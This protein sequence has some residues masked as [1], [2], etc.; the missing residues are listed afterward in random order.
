L[1]VRPLEA[2]FVTF[3]SKTIFKWLLLLFERHKS[4]S[5]ESFQTVKMTLLA[6]CRSFLTPQNWVL[7]CF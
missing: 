5:V 1:K 6:R 3:Y 7:F 4:C 2:E